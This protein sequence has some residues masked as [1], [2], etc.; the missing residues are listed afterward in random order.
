M[1]R[2]SAHVFVYGRDDVDLVVRSIKHRMAS[3]MTPNHKLGQQLVLHRVHRILHD[4]QHIESRQNRLRQFDV[5]REGDCR[6]VSSTNGIGGSDHGTPCLQTGDNTSFGDRDRLLLHSFVNTGPIRIVH[7]VE[8]VDETRPL[9]GEDQR[10][11]FER[12]FSC[13][14]VFPDRRR[15]T[16]G[17]CSLAGRKHGTVGGLFGVLQEL[18]LGG[19]RIA[20]KENVDVSSETMLAVDIFGYTAE[21]GEGDGSFDVVV[22]VDRRRDGLEDTLRKA[23]V[24]G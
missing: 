18:T 20:E 5:L 15:E 9:V 19:T 22:P 17:T 23:W 4:T 3:Q 2:K 10:P 7:L 14:G 12:P 8:F 11:S 1:V 6:I 16:Y 13:D 21:E 24:F